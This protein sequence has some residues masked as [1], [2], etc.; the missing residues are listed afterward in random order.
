M[1]NTQQIALV[2]K[3][4]PDFSGTAVFDQEFKN[5]QLSDYR[6]KYLVL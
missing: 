1:Q 2:G 4:A 6:N 3:Q 5:I